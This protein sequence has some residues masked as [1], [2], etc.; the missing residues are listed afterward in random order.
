MWRRN[1]LPTTKK[2]EVPMA[3]RTSAMIRIGGTISRELIPALSLN[4]A[5]NG[6]ACFGR[7]EPVTQW[8]LQPRSE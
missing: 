6:S 5:A 1:C 3:D 7:R 2:M 4:S 8:G